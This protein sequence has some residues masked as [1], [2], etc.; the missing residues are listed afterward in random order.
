MPIQLTSSAQTRTKLKWLSW[1][2]AVL[3]LAG[4]SVYVLGLLP[5]LETEVVGSELSEEQKLYLEYRLNDQLQ[6]NFVTL[7]I[8]QAQRLLEEESWI[9]SVLIEKKWPNQLSVR[10]VPK[11][12]VARFGS[13]RFVDAEGGLYRQASFTQNDQNLVSF[14]GPSDQTSGMMSRY[15][16]VN[17]WFMG[18]GYRLQDVQLSPGG[19]WLFQFEPALTVI[20]GQDQSPAK[21]FELSELMRGPLQP[22]LNQIRV[23]DLRYVSGLS[24]SWKGSPASGQKLLKPDPAASAELLANLP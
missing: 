2:V 1:L 4:A 17:R 13:N 10:V 11:V 12:P 23:V 5:E 15:E 18:L 16:I 24:I 3:V 22:A 14:Y 9:S 21:L 19:L 20:I 8:A 6:G 7:D